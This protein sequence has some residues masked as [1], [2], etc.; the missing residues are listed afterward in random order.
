MRCHGKT[1]M[2]ELGGNEPLI[3]IKQD[4]I[5]LLALFANKMLVLRDKRIE[6]LR[7]AQGQHLELTVSDEFLKI[8][9]DGSQANIGEFLANSV[10]N[11]IGGGMGRF[12]L[13]DVPNH[14]Q[15]PGI[16]SLTIH[17]FRYYDVRSASKDLLVSPSILVLAR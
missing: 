14:F 11:L 7:P 5:D 8:S 10:V 17:N 9:I 12:V 6:V 16:S 2:G 13:D 15:L 3:G 1:L 4:V